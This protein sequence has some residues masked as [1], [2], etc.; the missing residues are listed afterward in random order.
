MEKPTQFTSTSQ[1]LAPVQTLPSCLL[2]QPGRCRCV[3]PLVVYEPLS[4]ILASSIL[5]AFKRPASLH[6]VCAGSARREAFIAGRLAHAYDYVPLLG[7]KGVR[8]KVLGFRV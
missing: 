7:C 8:C 2:L 1:G 4:N 6:E 3:E 5:H